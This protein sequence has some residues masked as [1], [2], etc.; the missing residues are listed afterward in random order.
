MKKYVRSSYFE[1]TH[2]L[3]D[4]HYLEMR[5]GVVVKCTVLHYMPEKSLPKKGVKCFRL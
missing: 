4:K 5:Q 1:N 2:G 3:I